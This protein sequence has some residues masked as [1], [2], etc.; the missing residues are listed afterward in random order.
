[1]EMRTE[2]DGLKVED[3]QTAQD[4]IHRETVDQ[5]QTKYS[6][7]RKVGKILVLYSS[8]ELMGVIVSSYFNTILYTNNTIVFSLR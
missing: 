4:I 2:I 6:T 7:L 3:R 8:C 1:M 5:G